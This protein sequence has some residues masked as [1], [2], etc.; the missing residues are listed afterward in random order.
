MSVDV[1]DAM[2][3]KARNAGLTEQTQ[4][5]LPDAAAFDHIFALNSTYRDAELAYDMRGTLGVR[6]CTPRTGERVRKYVG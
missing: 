3:S 6:S 5:Y 2:F 1:A 4:W